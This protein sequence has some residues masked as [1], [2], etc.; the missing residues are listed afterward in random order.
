MIIK[1]KKNKISNGLKKVALFFGGIS[2]EASVSIMSASNIIDNFDN[3]KYKLILIYWHKD[4]KFYLLQNIDD[5][6]AP[7]R[8]KKKKNYLKNQVY[9]DNFKKYFDIAFLITHGKYGED[10]VLQSILESQKIKYTGCKVLSSALCMDKSLFKDY[11]KNNRINQVKYINID[12]NK[13][14]EIE[15]K[16][17]KNKIKKE[18]KLPIYIKPSNSGSSVGISRVDNFNKFDLAISLA[19]KHDN[20]IIIEEGVTNYQEIEIAV[21]G[22]KDLIVSAPGELKLLKDFYDYEDKYKLG[23]TEIVIPAKLDRK[24][25]NQVKGLAEKV[26]KLC[27]CSGFVRIDFFVKNKKIYVNEINTL[28][29]FTNISMF[30]RLI[31]NSGFTYRQMLNKIIELAN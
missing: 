15:I 8:D 17:L 11:L 16:N 3:K 6:S 7:L 26:Y 9:I 27:D 20:K 2:N 19:L 29:G 22:N 24:S 5:L 10:G 23:K 31:M 28:P 12:Y 21:M 4:G 25:T 13:N 30:P 18:F 14:S 1:K